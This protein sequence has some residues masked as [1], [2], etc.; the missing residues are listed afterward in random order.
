MQKKYFKFQPKGIN[1][2]MQES[3][4]S[5]Q[6]AT[7]MKNIRLTSLGDN[8]SLAITNEIGNKEID[9]VD[10][11]GNKITLK[12]T[13]IGTCLIDK[14]LIVFTTDSTGEIPDYI[15]KLELQQVLNDYKLLGTVLYN[16]NLKFSADYPLETLAVYE[17]NLVK[18]VYWVDGKNQARVIN[19]ENVKKNNDTQF[20]FVQEVELKEIVTIKKQNIGGK[21]P[22]GI[23]QYAISYYN[24]YGAQTNII[25]QSPLNYL[26]YNKGV[27]PEETVTCSFDIT[28]NN[29]DTK[30][31]YLRLYSIVRTSIDSTPLVKRVIDIDLKTIIGNKCVITDNGQIGDTIDPSELLYIGGN[32]IYPYT[33]EQKDNHLFLGNYKTDNLYIDENIQ[34]EIRKIIR[35]NNIISFEY[36]EPIRYEN[37]D[38]YTKYEGLLNNS[39]VNLATFKYMEWYRVGIQFQ[40]KNGKFSEVVYIGDY[41]N[42]KKPIYDVDGNGYYIKVARLALTNNAIISTLNNYIKTALPDYKKLR[43]MIVAPENKYRSIVCQGIVSST[44]FNLQDRVNNSPFS[45]S[46]WSMRPLGH[47]YE[48]LA[49]NMSRDAEIQNISNP[50][51]VV[52]NGDINDDT[53]NVVYELKYW[54]HHSDHFGIVYYYNLYKIIKDNQGQEINRIIVLNNS[55][56]GYQYEWVKKDLT[57]YIGEENVPTKADWE[58]HTEP[59]TKE[60]SIEYTSSQVA[61]KPIISKN[62]NL[63]YV[64]ESIL[65]LNTPD[66]E[67]SYFN[68]KDTSN[69]RLVGIGYKTDSFANYTVQGSALMNAKK[70]G[71]VQ[72]KFKEIKSQPLWNDSIKDT[73]VDSY[74]FAT[75]IWHR[76]GSLNADT[77]K[78]VDSSGK[79]TGGTSELQ[80]KIISNTR[81][82]QTKYFEING[83][84]KVVN[85]PVSE[86]KT[87]RQENNLTYRFKKNQQSNI[88]DETFIYYSDVDK[89]VTYPIKYDE[90]KK[91]VGY[92]IAGI[93]ITALQEED[94]VSAIDYP[95]AQVEA[96][97]NTSFD[98]VH[99]RYKESSHVLFTLKDNSN[100]VQLLPALNDNFRY[101][102]PE[103]NFFWNLQNDGSKRGYIIKFWG[104]KAEVE[105]QFVNANEG[106]LWYNPDYQYSAFQIIHN[107]GASFSS[108]SYMKEGD[109]FYYQGKQYIVVQDIGDLGLPYLKL[110]FVKD[111]G[112]GYEY[113]SQDILTYDELNTL[114]P[115]NDVYYIADIYNSTKSLYGNIEDENYN[116]INKD[117]LDQQQWI[118]SSDTAIIGQ[119]Y[120]IFKGVG[121]TYFQ[122]WDCLKTCAY[123]NEDKNQYIDITSLMIESRINLD[124]RYDNQRGL[125]FNLG[126]N[127]T[128]FNLYNDIFSQ[129][130]NFFNYRTLSNYDNIIYFPNQISFSQIK[131]Y[132]EQIDKWTNVTLL[133]TI[134]LDG[135]KGTL[136]KIQRYNNELYCFQ[137][138]GIAKLLFNSRVQINTND[139]VPIEIA[140]GGKYQDKL[141][142]SNTIGCQNKHTILQSSNGLYFSDLNTGTIYRITDKINDISTGKVYKWINKLSTEIWTPNNYTFK[143]L[144]NKI[145][146]D[147]FFTNK[148]EALCMNEQLDE[149]TSFY[150]YG[151]VQYIETI[152]NHSLQITKDG[153][154]WAINEGTPNIFFGKREPFEFRFIV[155]ADFEQ[156]KIFE[157][158]E[159]R[160][161][162]TPTI[163]GNKASQYPLTDLTA[164]NEYQTSNSKVS[165]LRKKFNV[166]R[167]QISRNKWNR[168]K[169]ADRIRNP[170]VQ[171]SLSNNNIEDTKLLKIYDTMVTYYV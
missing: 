4:Q 62:S 9:I 1:M 158:V 7:Y 142:I 33:I 119:P 102:K 126:S 20:D 151:D 68:I 36:S 137:N 14:Y 85:L 83:S 23:I 84:A 35:D 128:N 60:F 44:L 76:E 143:T 51:D 82:L 148:Q 17:N 80:K 29:V 37:F 73:D 5:N 134:D 31:D 121:D 87:I 131:T 159:F 30:F 90:N 16:G 99:I 49:D 52:F 54:Y 28:I 141:Y 112:E 94:V 78:T 12:G 135:D 57:P 97:N 21:F 130:N 74:L 71:Q 13:P 106:D 75:Y 64:D 18:K 110:E 53:K 104:S 91:L 56:R 136:Q 65:T 77:K 2:D 157:A 160:S 15:Y 88:E 11:Q 145:T 41:Q 129:Q 139:G 43:L 120:G 118:P 8:T 48:P 149:Y 125:I 55:L 58:S 95:Y 166:W 117:L 24:K 103:G 25:Y 168:A 170:W 19:I 115:N 40:Y 46:S 132:G 34:K 105:S 122:R 81:T 61:A 123:S 6:Y 162:D 101:V 32:L 144:Y 47:N 147:I 69:I 150:S 114:S 156:D 161:N 3:I 109:Y 146:G 93:K 169:I 50:I 155:N 67:Q 167:W 63:F 108:A 165:K 39:Q 140:N 89:V 98:P 38:S 100:R 133:N 70:Q 107:K 27:T 127:I 116:I 10:T 96:D 154:I 72:A 138:K 124:G 26:A 113:I 22:S 66:F 59:Y 79:T 86:I 111:V 42:D 163:I 153:R 171:L 45:I 92:P 164:S 152:G